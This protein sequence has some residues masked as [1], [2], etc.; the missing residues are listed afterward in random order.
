MA[1][2]SNIVLAHRL[3]E[4]GA[5]HRAA[6]RQHWLVE[7]LEAAGL[8]IV[9]VATAWCGYNAAR[10]DGRQSLLYGTA[11]RLRV[12]AALAATE[13]WQQR[14]LDVVTFNTWI[15][16]QETKNEKVAAIY[17]HRFSPEYKVAFDAWLKT[18]PFNNP[19][20]PTGPINMPEY[21]NPLLLQSDDL[22]RRASECFDQGTQARVNSELYVRGTVLLATILFLIALAQ[23]F[24]VHSVRVCLLVVAA[25]LIV[26]ALSSVAH[27]PRLQ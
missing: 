24:R 19:N 8:S 21:R 18:D 5:E 12:E 27:Y 22:N 17:V 25:I 13:G 2:D 4:A 15:R 10:W 11:S 9:A 1:E 3:A 16:L 26:Y 7:I 23:R 20:A 6:P 14:L